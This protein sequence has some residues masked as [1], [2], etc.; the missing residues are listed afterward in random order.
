MPVIPRLLNP[1]DVEI[2]FLDKEVVETHPVTGEPLYEESTTVTIKGQWIP[3][4]DR[5]L[6][7]TSGGDSPENQ[8]YVVIRAK[9]MEKVL[10]NCGGT[11]RTGDKIVSIG[12]ASVDA[13]VL[14][15]EHHSHYFGKP[16]LIFLVYEDKQRGL[17]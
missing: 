13:V 4:D 1:V 8:G 5:K 7:P 3:V 14:S 11:F 6:G 15:V 10:E 16:Q 2:E 17:V 12:G 9:D